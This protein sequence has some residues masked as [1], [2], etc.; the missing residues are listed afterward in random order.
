MKIQALI[1][2]LKH[3]E[4]NSVELLEGDSF[5]FYNFVVVVTHVLAYAYIIYTLGAT[6]LG[7]RFK[8]PLIWLPI[9][10]YQIHYELSKYEP[11]YWV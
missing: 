3:T 2:Y 9:E 5:S 11:E 4:A 8:F 7:I 10:D 6:Y 1:V